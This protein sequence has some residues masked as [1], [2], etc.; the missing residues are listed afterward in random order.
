MLQDIAILTGGQ[1]ISEDLGIRLEN[2]TLQLLGRAK[3]V[4]IDKEN[5]TIVNGAGSMVMKPIA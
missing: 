2:V 3:K 1:A 4:M 5:T